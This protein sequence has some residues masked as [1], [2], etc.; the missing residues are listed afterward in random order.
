VYNL[1]A[2]E[3]PDV[4]LVEG[5]WDV[6]MLHQLGFPHAAAL[7]TSRISSEQADV[8][9]RSGKRVIILFDNDKAGREGAMQVASVLLTG[10]ARIDVVKLPSTMTDLKQVPVDVL[11]AALADRRPYP[12]P[13]AMF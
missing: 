13:S 3:G 6:W 4:L 8:V 1:H 11:R 7:M 10:G 9:L 5:A 12:A 2:V